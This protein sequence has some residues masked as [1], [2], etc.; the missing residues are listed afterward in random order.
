MFLPSCISSRAF[1]GPLMPKAMQQCNA[2][3]IVT[4]V[5]VGNLSRVCVDKGKWHGQRGCRRQINLPR[6]GNSECTTLRSPFKGQV[7]DPYASVIDVRRACAQ[8]LCCMRLPQPKLLCTAPAVAISGES[9]VPGNKQ[10]HRIGLESHSIIRRSPPHPEAESYPLKVVETLTLHHGCLER[11]GAGLEPLPAAPL[12]GCA[13]LG[14]A[15]LAVT[16]AQDELHFGR[17]DHRVLVVCSP[18]FFPL[19]GQHPKPKFSFLRGTRASG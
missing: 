5:I 8:F 10:N 4:V 16:A 19:L 3:A 12:P 13:T 17:A 1:L 14:A 18:S 6:A 11:M 7:E 15:P 2:W 9:Y